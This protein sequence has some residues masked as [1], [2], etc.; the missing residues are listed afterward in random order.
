MRP[1]V[2]SP[3][4]RE[5]SG[6]MALEQ[7]AKVSWCHQT[8]GFFIKRLI[9]I[10]KPALGLEW[11]TY[12]SPTTEPQIPS[13]VHKGWPVAAELQAAFSILK[14][15]PDSLR[16]SLG[17]N[18]TQPEFLDPGGL[19]F[20]LALTPHEFT[21]CLF[22]NPHPLTDCL[23]LLYDCAFFRNEIRIQFIAFLFS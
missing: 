18:R 2:R 7:L 23:F 19:K 13:Q 12:R 5:A 6:L 20:E 9:K 17:S 16:W 15:S 1:N 11:P 10:W 8:E 22:L 4:E 21:S 14:M 3:V